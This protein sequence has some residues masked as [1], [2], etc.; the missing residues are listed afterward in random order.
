[1]S[2][3]S[4]TATG[5]AFVFADPIVEPAH[6]FTEVAVHLAKATRFAGATEKP[7]S[8]AQHSV[9]AAE[10]ALSATGDPELAAFVLLHDAHQTWLGDW[11]S[12]AFAALLDEIVASA[13]QAGCAEL[14]AHARAAHA[15]LALKLLKNRI[16][17]EVLT[18]AGLDFERFASRKSDIRRYDIQALA[19]ERRDLM[20]RPP[21]A[22]DIDT[23]HGS[24]PPR[25][26]RVKPEAWP[27]A[28][29]RFKALLT[30]LCPDA[31]RAA[32]LAA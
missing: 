1:L 31:A 29:E 7:I 26:R 24:P 11:T 13:A 4:Q 16:D 21:M 12:P 17:R 27:V 25:A 19:T 30:Q 14:N 2:A 10:E 28:E 5:R 9:L 8:I 15:K 32:N 23:M 6:L 3:W 22:W 18:A 20:K